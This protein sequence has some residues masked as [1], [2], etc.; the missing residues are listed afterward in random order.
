[1]TIVSDPQV[2]ER[3]QTPY[4]A[5]KTR[6]P[7]KGLEFHAAAMRREIEQWRLAH[8]IVT[9][10]PPFLR[11][12][13]IDLS[14]RATVSVGVPVASLDIATAAAEEAEDPKIVADMV[15]G[16]RYATLTYTDHGIKA[17]LTLTKWCA[18]QGFEIARER[19]KTG[20]TFVARLETY[21]T[22]R[23]EESRGMP[24]QIRL[25]FKLAD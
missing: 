14:D 22:D 23:A 9:V 10:G 2:V 24:Q 13:V 16:G 1:M 25:E 8:A 3:P 5:F 19:D 15:P 21:L 11:L 7:F 4:I 18:K 6:V 17:N 12:H 20:N